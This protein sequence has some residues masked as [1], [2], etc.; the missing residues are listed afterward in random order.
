MKR[1][2]QR[3]VASVQEIRRLLTCWVG[4]ANEQYREALV[5]KAAREKAEE[6]KRLRS[7]VEEEEKLIRNREQFGL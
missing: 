7:E 4:C 2:R 3:H 6:E 1:G 5:R